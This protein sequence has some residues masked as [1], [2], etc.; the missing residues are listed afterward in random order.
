MKRLVGAFLVVCCSWLT[1]CQLT[2]PQM[3][4]G[5]IQM[6][7]DAPAVQSVANQSPAE[8]A[9]SSSP[10]VPPA[11]TPEITR[12]DLSTAL[13][14]ASGRSAQAAFAKARV[15]EAYGQLDRARALKLPSVRAGLNY[16]KHEGRI[17]DV[18]GSVI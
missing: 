1:G 12:L 4:A 2:A 10:T 18:A 3:Q 11:A 6:L 13:S 17:Q 7:A 8:T 5:A 16:N 14:L 15:E 9:T